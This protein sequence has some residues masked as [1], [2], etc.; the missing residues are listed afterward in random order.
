MKKNIIASAIALTAIAAGSFVTQA[1]VEAAPMKESATVGIASVVD[2]GTGM[3]ISPTEPAL[4]ELK[5]YYDS[6]GAIAYSPSTGYYGLA[7]GY[8]TQWGAEDR[9]L[10]ECGFNDCQVMWFRNGHG[11]LAIGFSS[12]GAA[13]GSTPSEAQANAIDLCR[14]YA[15]TVADANTCAIEYSL[16]SW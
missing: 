9:A 6:Y 1:P 16:S 8:E 14:S 11:A 2:E 7:W 10:Y 12:W 5:Q 13:W 15:P 4:V 3:A